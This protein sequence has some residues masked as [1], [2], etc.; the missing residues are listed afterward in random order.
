MPKITP[1]TTREIDPTEY[2]NILEVLIAWEKIQPNKHLYGFIKSDVDAAQP[3]NIQELGVSISEQFSYKL[4]LTKVKLISYHLLHVWKIIPGDRV[5]L[6]FPPSTDFLVGFFSCL[7]SGIIA[8]PIPAP[9][10][11]KLSIDLQKMFYISP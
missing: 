5:I 1:A 10:P 2:D 7:W 6:C 9:R 4:F 3:F 11:D 8:V